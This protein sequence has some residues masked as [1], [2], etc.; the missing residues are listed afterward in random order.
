[1]LWS[2]VKGVARESVADLLV[3]PVL[4]TKEGPDLAELGDLAP[5]GGASLSALAESAAFTGQAEAKLLVP[6]RDS[7][8]AWILLVGLGKP[9]ELSL[10]RW[11]RAAGAAAGQARQIKAAR[12]ALVLPEGGSLGYDQGSLAR[13]WVEGAEMALSP[14]GELKG[15]GSEARDD[16][17]RPGQWT[18]LIA[19][20][21][22]LRSVRRGLAEGEAYAAGCL[23]ARRLVNLPANLLTPVKLAA[24]ARRL[25]RAEGW[26]CRVLGPAQLQKEGQNG[27]LGVAQGSREEPRLIVIETPGPS[28]ATKRALTKVALIGKGVTFD[29]GGLS[30]KPP[31]RMDKMKSDMSG[32]AAVLGAALSVC[33]LNLPVKLQIVIPAAENLPDGQALKPGDVLTMASGKTVEVLNTDAE[34]R[35]LLADA[36]HFACQR[37]PD[38]LVDIATLT[39]SCELALGSHFAGLLSNCAEL[40]EVLTQAGGETFERVWHL[41][42]ISEHHKSIA[43]EVADIQNLGPRA[44]G[45]LTAAAFLAEFVNEEIPWAHLDIAGTA[46][47][48]KAGSLGPKGA[49]GYGSRLLARA[50]EI[51]VS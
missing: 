29:S 42:L 40:I 48:D 36:L 24:E 10:D 19:D 17:D 43:S 21:R 30:L 11:R 25:A 23:L 18:V 27:L 14:T 12:C 47:T 3:I 31:T 44:G 6:G 32:A 46:W 9:D 34:G 2:V 8:A 16:S 51:L 35:L 28:R 26:R 38:F 13:C 49:T 15:S 7:A 37:Q 4:E 5:A 45:A 41:P 22:R 33:R 20:G 39:G 1:M 50:V